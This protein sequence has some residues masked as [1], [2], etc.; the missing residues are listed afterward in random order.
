M[1]RK[2]IYEYHRVS[3]KNRE[4][5]SNTAIYFRALSTCNRKRTCSD[6]LDSDDSARLG[7]KWCAG[8]AH[9]QGLCSDGVDRNRQDWLSGS[10]EHHSVGVGQADKCDG[11]RAAYDEATR[12][13]R[14]DGVNR[15]VR[16]RLHYGT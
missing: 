16:A 6:C 15:R 8:A 1:R 5:G 11:A 12:R 10:C 13:D 2:T 14:M 3:M 7:C 9:G 4:I